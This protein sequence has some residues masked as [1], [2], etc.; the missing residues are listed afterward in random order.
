MP[1]VLTGRITVNGAQDA[2]EADIRQAIDDF[3]R[4]GLGVI[5]A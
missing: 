2:G 1:V 5:A 4:G 3:N